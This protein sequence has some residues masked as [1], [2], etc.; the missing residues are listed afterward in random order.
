MN[1]LLAFA[2]FIVFAVVHRFADAM[3][4][5]ACGAVVAGA[6]VLR[7]VL[8]RDRK[9]KVLEIGT[10]ILFGGLALYSLVGM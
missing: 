5:L 8:S 4:G 7:D 10:L 6:L 1:I 2:P 3:I 9:V